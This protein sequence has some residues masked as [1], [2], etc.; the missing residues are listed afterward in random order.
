VGLLSG[1]Y[2]DPL[3][4][5]ECLN[6]DLSLSDS[7]VIGVKPPYRLFAGNAQ[8][9][10]ANLEFFLFLSRSEHPFPGALL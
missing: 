5:T 8:K 3:R 1:S 4:Q 10:G 9:D 2:R 6:G 7:R